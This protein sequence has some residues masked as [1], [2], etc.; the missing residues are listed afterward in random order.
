MSASVVESSK[1]GVSPSSWKQ[2]APLS[3]SPNA[4]PPAMF[5][6]GGSPAAS[7]GQQ[8]LLS[9][10]RLQAAAPAGTVTQRGKALT[11][12]Q[13]LSVVPNSTRTRRRSLSYMN[14]VVSTGNVGGSI[15]QWKS[16]VREDRLASPAMDDAEARLATA[17]GQFDVVKPFLQEELPPAATTTAAAAL[18]AKFTNANTSATAID[19]PPTATAATATAAKVPVTS[20]PAP[21]ATTSTTTIIQKTVEETFYDAVL[22]ATDNDFLETSRVRA[23]FR[24]NAVTPGD[25]QLFEMPPYLGDN[26]DG[27]DGNGGGGAATHFDD[28]MLPCDYCFPTDEQVR[29]GSAAMR[30]FHRVKCYLFVMA[31]TAVVVALIVMATNNNNS[32]GSTVTTTTTKNK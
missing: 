13:A 16:M 5:P 14:S 17:A 22:I 32:N 9:R 25:A 2:N 18:E 31:V 27:G 7:A 12:L 4:Y 29:N 11:P 19:V 10:Q 21:T 15:D 24:D 8:Q 3:A 6:T 20:K 1:T 23:I 28:T 26:A 30:I